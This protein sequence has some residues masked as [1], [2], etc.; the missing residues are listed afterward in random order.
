[1]R[2]K[3]FFLATFPCFEGY[4]I[5]KLHVFFTLLTT[6]M[7]RIATFLFLVMCF[8]GQNGV[9]QTSRVIA[10][11]PDGTS[12]AVKPS[13]GTVFV[14][15]PTYAEPFQA[16]A[17]QLEIFYVD[18]AAE[19]L[20]DLFI[21]QN[22]GIGG[23]PTTFKGF[24]V[25]FN[26]PL[27]RTYLDSVRVLFALPQVSSTLPQSYIKIKVNPVVRNYYYG[28]D[29]GDTV[30]I[31]MPRN[32]G[33]ALDSIMVTNLDEYVA[34]DPA[35]AEY[36]NF[37]EGGVA[38]KMNHKSVGKEFF[39]TVEVPFD[40]DNPD[41][42]NQMQLAIKGDL[43]DIPSGE[44][45]M[46]E[47]QRTVAIPLS[48]LYQETVPYA[49]ITNTEHPDGF[50]SNATIVAYVTDATTGVDDIKLE[51]NG[52]AQNFPNPFNPSTVIKYSVANAGNATL[53]VYNAL[54]S[55]VASLVNGFVAQ[56]EHSVNFDASGLPT[57][58][59]YY[60]LKSGD[61]TKTKHMVL[62]K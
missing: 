35:N 4:V 17:E 33:K 53:K 19:Q 39:I 59:Y 20:T 38:F 57:G 37:E 31:P 7:K 41:F 27:T 18:L 34:D 48:G 26:S 5:V 11:R 47:T 30:F 55:E 21:P 54:G 60:T 12:Q 42:E 62:S 50:Y 8:M 15:G 28:Y 40:N 61:F 46:P 44:H 1:M 10:L 58:T 3:Q 32:T 22:I 49:G 56:G 36:I 2:I 23:N 25:R 43:Y 13:Q 52:L 9:A 29:D 16:L 6:V 45:F 51:G 14:E 24:S